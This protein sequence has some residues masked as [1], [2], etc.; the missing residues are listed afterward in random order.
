MVQT[1]LYK[2]PNIDFVG[3][4]TQELA[5]HCYH[6]SSKRPCDMSFC[7]AEFSIINYMNKNGAP[8]VVKPMDIRECATKDGTEYNVLSVKLEATDT[9][10]LVGKFIYQITIKDQNGNVEIPSQGIMQIVNNIDKP[11]VRQT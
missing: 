1:D 3:G 4:S 10:E 7:N 8:L 5:F 9:V 2:L 6:H 11:F